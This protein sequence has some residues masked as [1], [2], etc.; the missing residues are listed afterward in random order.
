MVE[1]QVSDTILASNP[2]FPIYQRDRR[3]L[4]MTF[5]P[6]QSATYSL[7]LAALTSESP[8]GLPFEVTIA[9]T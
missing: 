1:S 2:Q 5:C 8:A 7:Y 3:D 4:N 6:D 9:A